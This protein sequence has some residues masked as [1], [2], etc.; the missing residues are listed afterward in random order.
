MQFYWCISGN[1]DCKIV[2]YWATIHGYIKTIIAWS[3]II[4]MLTKQE[5]RMVIFD[6]GIDRMMIVDSGINSVC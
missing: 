5:N 4:F 6:D 1:F 2:E 3:N